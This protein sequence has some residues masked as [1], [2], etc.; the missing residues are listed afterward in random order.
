[1]VERPAERPAPP[2]AAAPVAPRPAPP[3]ERPAV[4]GGPVRRE[5]D[6]LPSPSASQVAADQD[7]TGRA[8]PPGR[9][10]GRGNNPDPEQ[11][12]SGSGWPPSRRGG[13]PGNIP[14]AS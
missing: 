14:H 11:N 7:D 3:A 13:R 5:Q 6:A 8:W 12:G 1:M 10:P 2:P 9:R 4:A